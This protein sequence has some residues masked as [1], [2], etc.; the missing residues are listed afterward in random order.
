LDDPRDNLSAAF[1]A[2]D[3]DLAFDTDRV[4]TA[5]EAAESSLLSLSPSSSVVIVFVIV[6]FIF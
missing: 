5:F 1:C 3:G 2:C 6:L 4:L